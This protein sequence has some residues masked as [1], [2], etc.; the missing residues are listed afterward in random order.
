[1]SDTPV[2][3]NRKAKHIEACL[4]S[5][6]RSGRS[7]GLERYR[8]SHQALPELDFERVDTRTRFLGRELSAPL[9]ISPMTGGTQAA[10]TINENLARAAQEHRIVMGVGSQRAA[11]EH[12]ELRRTFEIRRFAPD[13]VLFANLGAVQLNKGMGATECAEAV[14]MIEADAL[15][16]H[17]NP[18]QEVLQ[19]GGDTDFSGLLRKIEHV[20]SRLDVPVFV[21]E[22][23]SGISPEVANAL[24]SAGVSGIDVG[25]VGGTSWAKVEGMISENA[26]T[27]ALSELFADWGHDVAESLLHVRGVSSTCPLIASGGIRDGLAAA[28]AIALGA[29]VASVAGGFL[30]AALESVDAVH[31]VIDTLTE[32]LRI[33]LFCSGLGSVANLKGH[34]LEPMT[35]SDQPKVVKLRA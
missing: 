25:G 10:A 19:D 21:R 13:A 34:F 29:D 20:C 3:A 18:L 1:M 16:L 5:E 6:S 28:K 7:N 11:L 26:R 9:M 33:T 12:E 4:S 8:F 17:L 22:V 35:E 15:F 23:S 14:R 30:Q 32:G 27:A 31:E 24:L 2:I